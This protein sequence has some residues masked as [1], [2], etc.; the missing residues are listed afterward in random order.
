[1]E[2]IKVYFTYGKDENNQT[3]IKTV[4][5]I[6]ADGN[7]TEV[8]FD[9]LKHKELWEDFN[10]QKLIHIHGVVTISE[11]EKIG[12]FDEEALTD[13]KLE[14]YNNSD[15]AYVP[16]IEISHIPPVSEFDDPDDYVEEE[17][18]KSQVGKR[19]AAGVLAGGA[20]IGALT[21]FHSCQKV[22]DNDKTT[23]DLTVEDLLNQMTEEQQKFFRASLNAAKNFNANAEN[24]EVFAKVTDRSTLYLTVDETVALNILLN[25]YSADELYNVFGTLEFNS[26]NVMELA[27]S[28]YGKLST[29]YM[30]AKAPSGI[31]D[32]INDQ[33]ARE[34][35]MRHENAIIEFNNEPSLELAD[36]VINGLYSDYVQNG[37]NGEYASIQNNGVAWFA[38]S[39]AFA[40]EL[41][42]RNV[43][44]FLTSMNGIPLNQVTSNELLGNDPE[45]DIMDDINNKSLC[46]ASAKELDNAIDTLSIRQQVALSVTET[47]AKDYLV[48]GIKDIGHLSL[49][50]KVLT[51]KIS[52]EL[53]KEVSSKSAKANDLVR[54]YKK[55]LESLAKTEYDVTNLMEAAKKEMGL[56]AE[57]DIANLVNN[58]FRSPLVLEKEPT[59]D[60][61]PGVTTEEE[62]IDQIV[63]DLYVGTDEI[64]DPVYDG[65]KFEELPPEIKD[66]VAEEI[67]TIVDVTENQKVEVELDEMT[68]EEVEQV[69]SEEEI[70]KELEAERNRLTV[71]GAMEANE[72]T[73]EKGAY[74]YDGDIVIDLTGQKIDTTDETLATIAQMAYAYE[75]DVITS[76]DEQITSRMASD[77]SDEVID[78]SSDAIE[79][80]KNKYGDNW[81]SIFM[82]ESYEEGYIASIDGTLDEAQVQG[83]ILREETERLYYEA[84]EKFNGSQ[85][86]EE[87]EYTEPE[88]NE[89]EIETP[90]TYFPEEAE[91]TDTYDPNLDPNYSMPGEQPYIP[92]VSIEIPG[93]YTDSDLEGAFDSVMEEDNV[94]TK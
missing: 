8:Y 77:A 94:K 60:E 56:N 70:L 82:D 12:L 21:L 69:I 17:K 36:K 33:N 1:M 93:T 46:A 65:D 83:K 42:N 40:Y 25:N 5:F 13:E 16:T 49:A 61:T 18:P 92:K 41:A 53:L 11:L 63:D 14:K 29:Y 26:A 55:M 10:A 22:E 15:D 74:T 43:P 58:R 80:L 64:G 37:I 39:T 27:R 32:M 28:A 84:L 44:E 87:P 7:L 85:T 47:N 91:T 9:I 6:D 67:G 23:Q 81:E 2:N 3:Q 34:F 89:P 31:A 90:G 24:E 30:N 48:E 19:I 35:F 79:Y 71:Q 52:D 78:L 88:Y 72:F 50:N 51:S 76:D 75:N 86:T 38:T 68:S 57:I 45:I 20:V 54:D 66:G 59:I 73:E 4:G 62:K